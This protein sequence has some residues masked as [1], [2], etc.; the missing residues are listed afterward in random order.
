ML[1]L[2]SVL[3]LLDGKKIIGIDVFIPEDLRARLMSPDNPVRDMMHLIE[4][5]LVDGPYRRKG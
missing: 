2:A 5:S 1:F 3:K 4:G